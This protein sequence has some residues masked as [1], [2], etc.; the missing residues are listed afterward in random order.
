M[1]DCARA[2]CMLNGFCFVCHLYVF[3]IIYIT[4]IIKIHVSVFV[5]QTVS[6]GFLH[7]TG[8]EMLCSLMLK[9]MPAKG[10]TH[11][12]SSCL[13]SLSHCWARCCFIL[14]PS[15]VPRCC[16]TNKPT[17]VHV[18][19]TCPVM[20]N[21]F[22]H[23]LRA[24]ASDRLLQNIRIILWCGDGVSNIIEVKELTLASILSLIW[25]C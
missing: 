25:M 20:W 4:H 23:E 1:I 12:I 3:F 13:H 11:C 22:R 18:C 9:L 5:W 17:S 6:T 21:D 8:A 10:V 14:A 19:C 16:E 7:G 15:P 24:V 2:R